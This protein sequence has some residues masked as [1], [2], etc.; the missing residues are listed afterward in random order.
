[1]FRLDDARVQ[2]AEAV[3]RAVVD[4]PADARRAELQERCGSDAQLCE[5]VEQ[6]LA[7]D[8]DASSLLAHT[9]RLHPQPEES[10]ETPPPPRI[11]RYEIVRLI[12]EGGMGSVFEARQDNPRRSVAIKVIRAPL[13]SPDSV[14][15]FEYEAAI[16]GRLQHPGIAH[17]YDAGLS[18]APETGGRAARRPYFAMELIAGV[19]LHEFVRTAPDIRV[20]LELFTQICDAVGHAHQKGVVHRDLKPANILV[21]ADGLPKILDFGVARATD[22][23][24]PLTTM[25]TQ[26]AQVLGTIPYMS[27]EQVS[28][29]ADQLDTRSDIYSLGVI[30]YELLAERRPYELSDKN[31][32]AAARV[33]CEQPPVPLGS[34]RRAFRG[35]LET[36]VHKA[37]EKDAV[38]RY[39]SV[40][41]LAADVRRY[42]NH[43]PISAR[44]PS[45]PY[46][47]SRF[48]VRRRG[49]VIGAGLVTLATLAGAIAAGAQALRATRAERVARTV[50]AFLNEDLLAQANPFNQPNRDITLGEVVDRAAARIKGRFDDDPLAEMA[51]HQTL[52]VSYR[53]LDELDDSVEHLEAALAIAQRELR[54]N[55]RRTIRL[56]LELGLTY[57]NAHRLDD[58]ERLWTV[59]VT[60]AERVLGARHPDTLEARSNL[61]VLALN[62]NQPE[63]AEAIGRPTLAARR[64]TLG[65]DHGATLVSMSILGS[66]LERQGEFEEAEA[67]FMECL[68]RSRRALGNEHPDTMIAISNLGLF[69]SRLDRFA[70]AE[71]LTLEVLELRR[72][73]LGAEHNLT[74]SALNNVG[75]FYSLQHRYAECEPY[76]VQALDIR[77]RKLGSEHPDTLLSLNNLGWLYSQ[78]QRWDD[79]ERLLVELVTLSRQTQADSLDLD[80]SLQ[81]LGG[82]L[83]K[84]GRAAEAEAILLEA[85]QGFEQHM[86][87]GDWRRGSLRCVYGD[88]LR[89]QGRFEEA[90]QALLQGHEMVRIALGMNHQ[91]TQK[92]VK[93]LAALYRDWNR[94]EDAARWE[95]LQTPERIER[96]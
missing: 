56:E 93:N 7:L 63:K 12:G 39:A 30:L 10:P 96:P 74:V 84:R 68:E 88:C 62:R 87:P 42:L 64:A 2:A 16:L 95:A 17:V 65:N 13:A 79:A 77:R 60:R 51:V 89:L 76:Y 50:N 4:L 94:T 21:T 90:E 55:D 67:L 71:P 19:P 46:Q 18:E 54:P 82:F 92:S 57:R 9:M 32:V 66:A 33:I 20:R 75:Y 28:G 91:Q 70:E 29:R 3:F 53:G 85:M 38:R 23:D 8:R 72:R 49:V 37:L 36:I 73:V 44:A 15:R 14:R 27:P 48:A 11:G 25:H 61:A 31:L 52:G 59:A 58:A 41:A 35:D 43:E 83:V 40:H 34:V 86:P 6:L 78:M 26:A 45:L 80:L 5:L 47:L 22:A 1:M 24:L 81:S 69:Y